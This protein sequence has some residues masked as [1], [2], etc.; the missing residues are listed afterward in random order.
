MCIYIRYLKR[1]EATH[2]PLSLS[3]SLS[4]ALSLSGVYTHIT[5]T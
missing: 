5:H 2:E 3:L 1:E 4:L